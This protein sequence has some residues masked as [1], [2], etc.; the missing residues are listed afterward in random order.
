MSEPMKRHLTNNIEVVIHSDRC[1][2]FVG[3]RTKLK[4]LLILMQKFDFKPARTESQEHIPWEEVARDDI[5]KYG[6]PALCLRGA[7][8]KEGLTQV[9][10][11]KKL[12]ISQYNLSK[13]ENGKR[14]IGKKMAHRLAKVLKMDYRVFL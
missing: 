13:M 10:L 11:C 9:A 7:R 3:P 2:H 5:E 6:M 1:H 14:P 8:V 4:P 12:G